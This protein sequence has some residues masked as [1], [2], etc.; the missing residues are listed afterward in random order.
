MATTRGRRDQGTDVLVAADSSCPRATPPACRPP[1]RRHRRRG[2]PVRFIYYTSGTT[3]E[4]KGAR[5]GDRT[6]RTASLGMAERLGPGRRRPLR[7][8]VPVHPRGRRRVRVRGDGLRADARARRGLRS[9]DHHRPPAPRERHPG[10]RGHVLP[11]D[12]PGRPAGAARGERLFP[13]VRT[14]PAGGARSRRACTTTL[15]AAFGVGRGVGLRP[16]R[17]AHPHDERPPTP[18]RSWPPPRARRWRAPACAS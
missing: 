9:R 15:K 5:H 3:A 6:L 13:H 18:T 11:P 17:G 8:R 4:P 1:R 10:R 16:D 2:V 12:V 7:P 14:F